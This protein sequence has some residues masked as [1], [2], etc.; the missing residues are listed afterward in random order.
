MAVLIESS[1]GEFVIDL[2][3]EECPIACQNF[4]DLCKIKYYHGCLFYSVQSNSLVQTGDP[5]GTGFGG[6]SIFELLHSSTP[7]PQEISKSRK[8]D[9]VGMVCVTNTHRSQF[10]IT[11]RADD[12]QHI[13][14][15]YTVLGEVAEGFETLEKLNTLYCDEN[16]RP[17]QD[18]RIKH[19]HVLDDP[20]EENP[21]VNI[22]SLVP[23]SSPTREVPLDEKVKRRI[24]YEQAIDDFGGR[25]EAEIVESI[26][27][28]EAKSRAMVLTMTGDIPDVDVKPPEEVLFVC[29]LNSVT[30]DA[31]LELIFSRFGPIKKCEII[32]DQKTGDSLNYAFIEFETEA[33]CI[34]AYEKMN[35]VLIDDRRIKVDFSQSVAHIWNKYLQRPRGPPKKPTGAAGA[36]GNGSSQSNPYKSSGGGSS[37]GSS[38]PSSSHQGHEHRHR[39]D[40]RHTKGSSNR[41]S[42]GSGRRSRSRSR[43][44]QHQV[45]ERSRD[46]ERPRDDRR[47][48]RDSRERERPRDRY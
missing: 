23:P 16:G 46:R 19:T 7:F 11:L 8:I 38:R 18:V 14:G 22:Q 21:I 6:E 27:S 47:G 31:D 36:A 48:R 40:S 4:I 39:E 5:T 3:V 25:T 1:C 26:E 45:R 17:F 35:N 24:P 13:E 42:G 12:W 41:N 29:K 30:T 10:F 15:K 9:K 34:E 28:R 44:K 33:A 2:F 37:S 20:F 43:D 32:R